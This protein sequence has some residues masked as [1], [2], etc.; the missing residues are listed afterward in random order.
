M[1]IETRALPGAAIQNVDEERHTVDARV[2]SYRQ[3]DRHGSVWEP[4][5]MA[6]SLRAGP[7]VILAHHDPTRPIGKVISH[8]DSNE[9]LDLTIQMADLDAVPDAR[10]AFSLMRDGVVTGWSVGFSRTHRPEPV[11]SDKRSAFGSNPAKEFIRSASLHEVS[12][13]ATPSVPGTAILAIRADEP[14]DT[15][16]PPTIAEIERLF[17]IK[18]L[19]REEARALL[20][21][22]PEYRMRIVLGGTASAPVVEIEPEESRTEPEPEA[23]KAEAE[24]QDEAAVDDTEDDDATDLLA[25]AT[26]EAVVASARFFATASEEEMAA[27][28]E[29]IRQGILLMHA[30]TSAVRELLDVRGL[31][32]PVEDDEPS[33]PEAETIA[34]DE[35]DAAPEAREDPEAEVEERALTLSDKP[36]SQFSEADYTPAQYKAACLI[37]DGPA[38]DKSSGILP[39]REP[40]GTVNK[41]G[42]IAAAGRLNQVKASDSDKKA[43][44][45]AL[46][47]LYGKAGL[48]PPPTLLQAARSV[49]DAETRAI[50]VEAVDSE[51]DG[52]FD[53]LGGKAA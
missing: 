43:A 21:D 14:D 18:L 19:D 5:C 53:R 28:P 29:S 42:M 49:D 16:H 9:S 31:E 47:S 27:L 24:A 12:H 50:V 11:P 48:K 23:D 22:L 30:G 10:T 17:E 35:A 44:A 3:A 37:W 38:D 15:L 20:A 7:P 46:M 39:V 26:A 34:S 2:L 1:P 6:D 51:L 33:E 52:L 25:A 41:A 13:V 40:D 8:R 4:G 45:K 32:H 36:W